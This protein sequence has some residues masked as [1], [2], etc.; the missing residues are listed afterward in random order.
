MTVG[1]RLTSGALE[2]LGR[3]RPGIPR[4]RIVTTAATQI[5]SGAGEK[6]G[7][8]VVV[9][10][11]QDG[12]DQ[13][14][15]LV[16]GFAPP[17]AVDVAR[18]DV[19]LAAFRRA[20]IDDL[21]RDP[22]HDA[23]SAVFAQLFDPLQETPAHASLPWDPRRYLTNMFLH[24]AMDRDQVF[25]TIWWDDDPSVGIGEMEGLLTLH[26][27]PGTLARK[28]LTAEALEELY[29]LGGRETARDALCTRLCELANQLLAKARDGRRFCGPYFQAFNDGEP[30]WLLTT[31]AEYDA[32]VAEQLL[33]PWHPGLRVPVVMTY[34]RPPDLG[35][36][37]FS[38]FPS[39]DDP[40]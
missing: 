30:N 33:V 4:D 6:I 31:A 29:R 28:R 9:D 21:I 38:K 39:G 27:V 26:G 5:A 22:V 1:A 20:G 8:T 40:F 23:V 24:R 16:R 12:A 25:P 15:V 3:E 2:L 32:L 17:H 35:E 37:D 7:D 10:V 13:V 19:A 14:A 34:K 11:E 18:F 36:I